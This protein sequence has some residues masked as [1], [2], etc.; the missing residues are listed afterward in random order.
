MAT[1]YDAYGRPVR[2]SDLLRKDKAAPTV[3]GVRSP[4][5]DPVAT[6]LTPLQLSEVLRAASEGDHW[7]YLTVAEEME[8]REMHY[9]SVLQTRRLAAGALDVTIES[10][11]DSAA[12]EKVADELRALVREDGFTS[13]LAAMTDAIAKGYSISEIAWDRSERQWW[14]AKFDWRDPR[15]FVFD[16]TT[17]NELLI[18]DETNVEGIPLQPYCFVRHIATRKNGLVVRGGLA[19]LAARGFLCKSYTIK[20]WMAFAE[21]FGL[22]LRIGRFTEGATQEDKDILLT[23]VANLGSDAAAIVPASMPIEIIDA[24]KSAGG[25]KLFA[26]LA[27]FWNKEMSKAILGQTMTSE[28]GS[29]LAQAKV[30]EDVRQDLLKADGV[31]MAATLQR[32]IIRPYVDL[33][34]GPRARNAYPRIRIQPHKEE[35]LKLLSESLP[36]FLDR[37]LEVEA[38]VIR[39]K[40][41]LPEPAKG[42]KLLG[43]AAKAGGGGEEGSGQEDDGDD[44]E[45]ET[46]PPTKKA[47]Q[48]AGDDDQD[49]IDRMVDA[50]LA[51]WERIVSPGVFGPLRDLVDNATSY[52]EFQKGLDRY[53]DEVDSDEVVKSLARQL[54]QSRGLGDATDEV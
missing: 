37:G 33:N 45:K 51:E 44:D 18:A 12:E 15:Y 23:A 21:V 50:E 35:D 22:P 31:A 29:S 34:Y 9:A 54:F 27:D 36:P 3:T 1:I 20:D 43:A 14:P 17:G 53:L 38:S 11:D 32:D 24:S 40:F 2:F 5:H 13:L 25:D 48:A 16:R 6:G 19:F 46:K 4:W 8:E 52:Q 7:Q 42:A 47:K 41:G 10:P 26:G 28:D 39:D 30:H 49:E